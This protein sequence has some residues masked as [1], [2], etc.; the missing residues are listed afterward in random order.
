[1]NALRITTKVLPGHRIEIDLPTS[2]IGDDVEVIVVLPSKLQ[3]KPRNALEIL[4]AAH[5]LGTSRTSEE[6]DRDLQTERES[7]DR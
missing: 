2:A 5:T 4:K 1:M 7:W 6:I 3:P